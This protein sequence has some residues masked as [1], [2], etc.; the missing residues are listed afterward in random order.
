MKKII[1]ISDLHLTSD[2]QLDAYNQKTDPYTKLQQ[3]FDDIALKYPDI[4]LIALT[5]DL[6]HEGVASD[7]TRLKTII[8]TQKE[9][10]G[11]NIH[12]ILGNHDR[13]PAF[14]EGYL[15]Q[16]PQDEYYYVIKSDTTSYFFLDTKYDANEQGML[17]SKQL[18]WLQEELDKDTTTPKI[19]F[20]H[21]PIYGLS[22]LHRNDSLIINSDQ[23]Y[24]IIQNKNVI[25]VL[26]GHLHFTTTN[27]Y[28]NILSITADSSAY[29]IDLTDQR[30]ASFKDS[31]SYNVITFNEHSLGVENVYLRYDAKPCLQY[32]FADNTFTI[33]N[34]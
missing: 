21:H 10:L 27:Y 8:D 2:G 14:F 18:A 29:H 30:Y 3:I 6:I 12:V 13:T 1:Q 32:S 23:L 25:G 16:A 28:N 17:S 31:I 11:V 34:D 9:K 19:L 24:E 4:E 5:G 33:P 15:N 22:V 26:S 20:T 7:Y